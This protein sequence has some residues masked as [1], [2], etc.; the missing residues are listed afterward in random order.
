DYYFDKAIRSIDIM[1]KDTEQLY[2]LP[3]TIY[4]NW[5]MVKQSA[6]D[7][8]TAMELTLKSIS[9]FN[10][11]LQHTHNHSLTEKVQGNLSIAYRNLG[12][13]YN[14]LGDKEKA[15]QVATLGYNH[16]K[17][18]FLPNTVQY[19]SAVLM[20]GEAHLYGESLAKARTFLE[21]A[22]ASLISVPGDNWSYAANLYHALAD[23]AKKEENFLEAITNYQ[24]TLEAYT[25][26][27][28][29]EFSQNI[30]FAR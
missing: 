26:S 21:E 14:D 16:A 17:K 12:S 5:T 3:G 7:Y 9:S 23:L 11:F 19:F 6:G 20:M 29:D 18:H 27:S 25:N 1:D 22:E 13:L 30:I 10:T 28:A 2:Y 8:G 24:K 15:I 4:G